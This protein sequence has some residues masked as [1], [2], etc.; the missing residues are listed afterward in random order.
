MK[1]FL[2]ETYDVWPL[3][4]LPW[5]SNWFSASL[6]DKWREAKSYLLKDN[7]FSKE[8]GKD[9][10]RCALV[11]LAEELLRIFRKRLEDFRA[12]A[13]Q[14]TGEDLLETADFREEYMD[15]LKDF[16]GVDKDVDPSWYKDTLLVSGWDET[17]TRASH[18]A[19]RKRLDAVVEKE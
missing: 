17:A 15:I 18:E 6:V 7:E 11:V 1:V 16:L 14:L 19:T 2:R 5:M 13:E 8:A 4:P 12:R 10:L 3:E 9:A